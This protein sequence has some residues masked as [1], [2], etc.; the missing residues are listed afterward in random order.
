MSRATLLLLA[1]ALVVTLTDST[2]GTQS[3]DFSGKVKGAPGGGKSKRCENSL[4]TREQVHAKSQADC[5][6]DGGKCD[7]NCKPV[8]TSTCSCRDAKGAKKA[9][10]KPAKK[11][12]RPSAWVAS[13]VCKRC[14]SD[15]P[16]SLYPPPVAAATA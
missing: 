2:L 8:F 10:K 12:V 9:T 1:L 15:T 4:L 5:D 16:C 3:R 11:K 7:G 6:G 13:F 14:T